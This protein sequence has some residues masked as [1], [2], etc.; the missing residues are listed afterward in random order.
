MMPLNYTSLLRSFAPTMTPF[1]NGKVDFYKFAELAEH[2]VEQGSDDIVVAGTTGEPSS[3]SVDVRIELLKSR[4]SRLVAGF[5]WLP[6]P[7][8]DEVTKVFKV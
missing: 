6:R 7:V 8:P 3:L 2:Q 4:F 5:K 1:S